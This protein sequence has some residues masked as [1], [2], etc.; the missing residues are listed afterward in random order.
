MKTSHF[1]ILI[2]VFFIMLATSCSSD[3]EITQEDANTTLV[4][5]AHD[6][7]TGE[8]VLNTNATMNGVNK[9]LLPTGCP[10]KFKFEWTGDQSLNISLLNFTVGNMGMIVNFRCN[11]KTMQLNS[12][13][14]K[15]YTGDGW[16]KIY[17][18]DGYTWGTNEDGTAAGDEGAPT[19]GSFVQGYYNANTNEIQFIVNYNMMNVRSECFLQTIDKSKLE[20]FDEDFAK[21]E[22]DLAEY[23]KEHGIQ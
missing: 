2:V 10:T 11:V 6:F 8:I 7:L 23:K 14:K 17:G 20:T 16:I 3:Q 5:K 18:E 12:W 13:E 19:K 22:K 15:E 1:S 9:T 21:Y 4:N